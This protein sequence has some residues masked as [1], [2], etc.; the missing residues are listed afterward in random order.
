MIKPKRNTSLVNKEV[1]KNIE[2]IINQKLFSNGY[3]FYGPEGVGKKQTAIRFIQGI[4]DQNFSNSDLGEKNLNNHPDF[5]SIE[6]NENIKSNIKKKSDAELTQ[7]NHGGIIKIEQIRNIK[8]FLSQKSIESGKKIILINDA[9]LLNEAAS[10]CLLKTLEEP[11]N[12]IFIL[13]T[14]KKN[15][16][17]ETIISRCQLIRFNS[18]SCK[19]LEIFLEQNLDFAKYET[20]KNLNFQDLVN[21]S[22]GSPKKLLQNIQIWSELSPEIIKIIDLPQKN[23][24]E[25]LKISKL[26]TEQLEIYQQTF[27]INFIQIKWWGQTKNLNVIRKLENLKF[28]INNYVQP[29]L[30]WEVNL[31]K[32][33]LEDL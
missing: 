20:Y 3:I 2:S 14:T 33:A 22:N 19:E 31:L 12:G 13:I 24:L 4:F 21:C 7:K 25:I 1:S 11:S 32:I 26:I 15:L 23:N 27:L 29:R 17:L 5:L 10:N 6:P 8:T 16:L 30:A 18:F 28:Q 9:H